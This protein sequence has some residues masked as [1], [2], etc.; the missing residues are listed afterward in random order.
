MANVMGTTGFQP[1][2]KKKPSNVRDVTAG[3]GACVTSVNNFEA[4][5]SEHQENKGDV[6]CV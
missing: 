4:L 2:D 6:V 5:S 3:L 1:M